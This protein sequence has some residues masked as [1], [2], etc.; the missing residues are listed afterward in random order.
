[1]AGTGPSEHVLIVGGE[2]AHH[3]LRAGLLGGSVDRVVERGDQPGPVG[4]VVGGH[5]VGS[6][7]LPMPTT[8]ANMRGTPEP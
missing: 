3:R 8:V 7:R 6:R 2:A 5:P 1:M 4:V